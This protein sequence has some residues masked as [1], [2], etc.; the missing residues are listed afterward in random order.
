MKRFPLIALVSMLLAAGPVARAADSAARP[1]HVEGLSDGLY[2]ECTTPRGAFTARLYYHLTPLVVTN[3]V[4]L[5]EG[6]LAPR[7][8]Q[9][10]YSGLKWYRVVPGFVIQ[11]GDPTNPGG[12]MQDRPPRDEKDDKAGHPFQFPDEIVPGLRHNAAGVLSMANDGPDTNSSEF[13]VT[14]RDTNRLNYLHSVFGRVVRGLEVLDQIQPGDALAIKIIRIGDDA[15]AFKADGAALQER[16][17]TAKKY[18]GAAEPGPAAHFDDPDKLL[19]AD[20]PRAKNFNFKLANFERF[21]GVRLVARLFA[22]SPP[23]DADKVPGAYMHALADKLGV[24]QH[25]ALAAYFADDKDW[26]IWIGADS[27]ATFLGRPT[28]AKDFVEEGAL[29]DAKTAFV[30]AAAEQGDADYAAQ[31]KAAPADKP[32]PPA[33]QLK[34]QTDAM[35][36]GLILKLEPK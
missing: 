36:D 4:G 6:S 33:Q 24:A 34:L 14:L 17:A 26:R 21:T 32:V 19:P 30:K 16:V 22:K 15:K 3:F 23:A 8:G 13:F 25:G 1:E 5:A 29:H 9:P 35:L 10:F 28:T 12:G 7:N 20:P 18:T 11:S 31:Q 27:A 2:A